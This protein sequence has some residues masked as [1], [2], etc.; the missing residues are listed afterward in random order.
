MAS[1]PKQDIEEGNKDSPMRM[2]P[3]DQQVPL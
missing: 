3:D 2:S 1:P